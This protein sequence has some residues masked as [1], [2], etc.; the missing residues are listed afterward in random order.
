MRGF[1]FEILAHAPVWNTG[2]PW[3]KIAE[4]IFFQKKVMKKLLYKNLNY[5]SFETPHSIIM[6]VTPSLPQRGRQPKVSTP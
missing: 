5:S 6:R 1:L 3:I 2:F 4:C